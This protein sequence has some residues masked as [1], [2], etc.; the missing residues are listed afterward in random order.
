MKSIV[1]V[2]DRHCL[3]QLVQIKHFHFVFVS[4]FSLHLN[5][6]FKVL[7][8]G[9]RHCHPIEFICIMLKGFHQPLNRDVVFW[10]QIPSCE[11]HMCWWRLHFCQ[12]I[13]YE[14]CGIRKVVSP[15]VFK[16]MITSSIIARKVYGISIWGFPMASKTCCKKRKIC[17]VGIA[18][19]KESIFSHP[20]GFTT[21]KTIAVASFIQICSTLFI[22][23]IV[24]F[25]VR[26]RVI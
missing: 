20:T 15:R 5:M 3:R 25:W 6:P 19:L 21:S 17:K 18:M 9:S 14:W 11:D 7:P 4:Y 26:Q 24:L 2:K 13:I 23:F 1:K 8:P 16:G 22:P 10:T 12:D